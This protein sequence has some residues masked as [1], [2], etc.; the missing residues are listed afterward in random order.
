DLVLTPL[1]FLLSYQSL[2]QSVCLH[3]GFLCLDPL[4]RIHISHQSSFCSL[5]LHVPT[6]EECGTSCHLVQI[7]S[8]R[9]Y[10]YHPL[11]SHC[12]ASHYFP[13]L[14]HSQFRTRQ[15]KCHRKWSSSPRRYFR[16]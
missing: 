14:V 5:A 13:C 16:K 10:V 15:N 12:A 2:K 7:P 3:K 8:R 11:Q 4:Q 1:T 9:T 6:G